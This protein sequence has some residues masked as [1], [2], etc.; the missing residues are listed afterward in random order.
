MV[1]L[2]VRTDP[3][4]G[5]RFFLAQNVWRG[6]Q[7]VEMDETYFDACLGTVFF[8]KTRQ[9]IVPS[10]NAARSSGAWV[11]ADGGSSPDSQGDV[12]Y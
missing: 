10:G 3:T 11:E 12:E 6:K 5:I 2:A 9:P 7:W 1:L 4:T 8:V